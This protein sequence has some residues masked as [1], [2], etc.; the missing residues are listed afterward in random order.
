MR[1]NNAESAVWQVTRS[2]NALL[3][4]YVRIL[5][6][7]C[8]LLYVVQCSADL[9]MPQMTSRTSCAA[10]RSEPLL[11]HKLKTTVVQEYE[12]AVIFRL[13]RLIGGGAKGPGEQF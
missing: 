1:P 7:S 13:G 2:G 5:K 10:I 12:R 3:P 6:T 11:R 8:V 4:R 9:A